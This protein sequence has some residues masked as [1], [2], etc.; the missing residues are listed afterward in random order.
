VLVLGA[1]VVAGAGIVLGHHVAFDNEVNEEIRTVLSDEKYDGLE[2]VE[3]RTEF[4]DGGLVSDET[5]VTVVVQRPA[6]QPYPTLVESV[7]TALE[8]RTDRE[9]TVSVEFVEGATTADDTESPSQ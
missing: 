8:D 4:N 5:G 7:Q 2:L 9:I 1:V 3:V 6:D